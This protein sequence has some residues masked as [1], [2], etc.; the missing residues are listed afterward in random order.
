V[1][2]KFS[3]TSTLKGKVTGLKKSVTMKKAGQASL[4]SAEA[5]APK[6]GKGEAKLSSDSSD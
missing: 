2:P 5:E 1:S 6:T 4:P 3:S